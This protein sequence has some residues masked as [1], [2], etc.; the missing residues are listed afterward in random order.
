M[1]IRYIKDGTEIGCVV[2][3]LQTYFYKK[4]VVFMYRCPKCQIEL[5]VDARFC[6][7]CGFNQTNARIASMPASTQGVQRQIPPTPST[8]AQQA[9]PRT[10]QP[11]NRQIPQSP[12]NTQGSQ[13]QPIR[14]QTP[15]ASY[16]ALPTTP[17]PGTP[18]QEQSWGRQNYGAGH[19]QEQVVRT[20]TPPP[21]IQKNNIPNAP[22]EPLQWGLGQLPDTP[23]PIVSQES[24]A[25]TSKAALHWRQSWLDRQHDEAGPAVGVSRGQAAV[26]EP[27]LKM[28]NSLVRM[29]AIILP[30]NG[31]D[32]K[33]SRLGF[34]L[35]VVMLIC[36]IVGFGA[37]I[38]STYS[39][40]LLGANLAS[41]GI[42]GEPTLMMK[43]TT[44][45]T[46]AAGQSVRV[47]GEHFG[48][49]DPILFSLDNTPVKG[50]GG[51][52]ISAQSND[53]GVFDAT[54]PTT[55]LAGEYTLQAQDNRTGQHAFLTIQ[56]AAASTTD[57][58]KLSATS[59]SFAS[60]VS[61][62]NQKAQDVSITNTSNTTIQWQA[63][64]IS[65]NQMGWLV[66][67]GGKTSGTLDP[68]K[69]DKIRVSVLT[70]EL[71][72]NTADH[73][74]IG[75][76]IV[77]VVDQ[78][79]VTLPVKLVLSD[80]AVELVI[81][82]NPIVAVQSAIPGGCQDTTLTLINLSNVEIHWNIQTDGFSQQ[83]ITLDGQPN[84]QGT[85]TPSASSNSTKVVKIGCNGVQLDKAYAVNVYYNGNQQLVPIS[86]TKG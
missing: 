1:S 19:V 26:P 16:Q 8:K 30:K 56:T 70:A 48:Q 73:P 15:M 5:P 86:I 83:S 14:Q 2:V 37:Y 33:N 53:K 27:L 60:N 50:A 46:I 52:P 20:S 45:T 31:K 69:T 32:G 79:Q 47:H 59:L 9:P 39:S 64:A 49:N 63:T 66:L 67:D 75:E 21:T 44:T 62:S 82:P 10:I 38:I 13:Q 54:I 11:N 78:G 28:Q 25:A 43:T 51:K 7:N 4:K 74:Y 36:L 23:P 77:T 41:S 80:T 68:G 24:L 34:L 58:L 29:R 6:K 18:A 42:G 35:P 84:E 17:R 3:R 12:N 71:T 61:Q 65:D 76:V 55:Q 22:L 85:L 40:G 81:N 57:V 72:S